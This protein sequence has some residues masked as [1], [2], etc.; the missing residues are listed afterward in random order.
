VRSRAVHPD[1][2]RPDPIVG[3]ESGIDPQH[4]VVLADS[5]GLALQVVLETPLP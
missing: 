5:V 1:E 3:P 4:E 2:R